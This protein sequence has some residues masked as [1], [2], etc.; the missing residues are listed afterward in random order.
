M[1]N[2]NKDIAKITCSEKVIA[3][4]LNIAVKDAWNFVLKD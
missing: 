1:P 4:L 3:I 2:T